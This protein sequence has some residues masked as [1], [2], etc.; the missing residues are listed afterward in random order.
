M[1]RERTGCP[2]QLLRAAGP[3]AA[4]IA[5]RSV[6]CVHELRVCWFTGS[7]L[8][9]SDGLVDDRVVNRRILLVEPDRRVALALEETI[10]DAG[11]CVVGR[12]T[13]IADA[14]RKVVALQPDL[15][16]VDRELEDEATGAHAL[17]DLPIVWLR[18]DEDRREP[19]F[20]QHTQVA[21]DVDPPELAVIVERACRATT[22]RSPRPSR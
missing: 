19:R 17:D 8:W 21:I 20:A 4:T 22:V 6:V 2:L 5:E 16:L 1:I 18:R 12:A 15:A 11:D 3:R 13:R 10:R 9:R 14:A 7:Q